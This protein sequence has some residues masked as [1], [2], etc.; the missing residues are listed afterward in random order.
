MSSAVRSLRCMVLRRIRCPLIAAVH[1]ERV[2]ILSFPSDLANSATVD[3]HH[4]SPMEHRTCS[5]PTLPRASSPRSAPM[6]RK[7]H[8]VALL[9]I[10]RHS[11]LLTFT[12]AHGRA[13]RS[14]VKTPRR[15][16]RRASRSVVLTL[17]RE[18]SRKHSWRASIR[19][20]RPFHSPSSHTARRIHGRFALPFVAWPSMVV[21]VR[22]PNNLASRVPSRSHRHGVSSHDSTSQETPCRTY[23]PI[24]P[25][26]D[27]PCSAAA[28]P[29]GGRHPDPRRAELRADTAT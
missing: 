21:T 5:E 28:D 22:S 15:A 23:G 16:L 8:A 18:E 10:T 7:L 19:Q 24:R 27:A 4:T 17:P 12:R 9:A 1:W 11:F 2:E 14:R 25:P 26:R 29:P 6:R 13:R 20:G 3:H